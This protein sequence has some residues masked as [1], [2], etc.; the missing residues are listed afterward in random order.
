MSAFEL[1]CSI[2]NAVG[3]T[4]GRQPSPI[5]GDPAKKLGESANSRGESVTSGCNV[6]RGLIGRQCAPGMGQGD[7]MFKRAV[8]L[9]PLAC[10]A[11]GAAAWAAD[12]P[13]VGD[14][15]LNPEKSK[16]TDDE[17]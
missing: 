8:L 11:A 10:L 6:P 15:K 14:W 17:L 9:L 5:A 2:A 16:L 1:R 4:D 13:M 3:E 7:S 12:D